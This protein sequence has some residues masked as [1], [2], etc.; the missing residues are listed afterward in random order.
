MRIT[1]VAAAPSAHANADLVCAPHDRVREYAV[2]PDD[3]KQRA[4]RAEPCGNRCKQ[5][6]WNDG[7]IALVVHPH[8]SNDG[9]SFQHS[10]LG[11]TNCAGNSVRVDSRADRQLRTNEAFLKQVRIDR[12]RRGLLEV[13]IFGVAD[14]SDHLIGFFA[15]RQ[16]DMA[17]GDVLPMDFSFPKQLRAAASLMIATREP[18]WSRAEKSR[19][20]RNGVPYVSK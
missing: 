10:G 1:S 20:A 17:E 11:L 12:G 9:N 5:P 3:C 18:A 14:D 13:V 16:G 4:Q 15:F 19:P 8:H 6:L 7:R 2:Q